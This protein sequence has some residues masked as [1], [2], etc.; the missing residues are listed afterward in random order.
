MKFTMRKC[1]KYPDPTILQQCMES[2]KL[3]YFE[4][5]DDFANSQMPTWNTDT[6]THV[7]VVAADNTFEEVG[8]AKVNTEVRSIAITRRGV[9]FAFYDT[10]AC[11]T[12]LALKIYY[13]MCPQQTINFAVF[14]N[15]TTGQ[16]Q[17]SIVQTD[18]MCVKY[19]AI[20]NPPTYLCKGDGT[21]IYPSG[22][23]KC[24]PGYEP[25]GGPV[26]K[27]RGE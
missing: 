25:A 20:E 9:Y 13:I 18:G 3:L 15:T 8:K 23:C 12:L 11:T 26:D 27:C 5:E 10:G 7:D 24:M 17:S 22:G 1:T 16:E 19:A 4:A 2:F 14:P 6:Y 21:W